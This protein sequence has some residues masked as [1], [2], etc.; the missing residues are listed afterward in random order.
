[1]RRRAVN[2]LRYREVIRRKSI[3]DTRVAQRISGRQWVLKPQDLAVALKLI[4]LYGRRF[5]Y[6]EL[7]D[8][9]MLSRYEAHAA[10]QRLVLAGLATDRDGLIQSR[11]S[12]IADFV[13]HGMRYAFPPVYT[14]DTRGIPTSY[15]ALSMMG[16]VSITDVQLNTHHH[17][18]VWPEDAPQL[19]PRGM[20]HEHFP[21]RCW[22]GQGM[23]PLYPTLPFVAPGD[24]DLYPL[25][26][27][28]D[29]LRSVHNRRH[30]EIFAGRFRLRLAR[31][32]PP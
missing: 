11:D 32:V 8:W 27:L 1:M 24:Y 17:V 19:V 23:L 3:H 2:R 15:L 6:S 26:A 29:A 10:T 16:E 28:V 14:G 30:L 31:E 22:R 20:S 7:A 9:M 4:T 12:A 21:P 5:T 25:V 18:V 13:L